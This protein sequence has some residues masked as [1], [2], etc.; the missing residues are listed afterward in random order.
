MASEKKPSNMRR[1]NGANSD[2]RHITQALRS[3]G[4]DILEPQSE[5]EI[6]FAEALSAFSSFVL[7]DE[8]TTCR[9]IIESYLASGDERCGGV[10]ILQGGDE[11]D[12]YRLQIRDDDENDDDEEEDGGYN[13]NPGTAAAKEMLQAFHSSRQGSRYRKKLTVA[14]LKKYLLSMCERWKQNRPP[15]SAESYRRYINLGNLMWILSFGSVPGQ[16]RHIDNIDPNNQICCYMSD[17]CPSTLVYDLD[18]PD[19]VCAEDLVEYWDEMLDD[20]VP[21]HIKEM[22]ASICNERLDDPSRRAYIPPRLAAWGSINETLSR[23]GKLYRPVRKCLSLP[24]DP[25]TTLVAGG[26]EVHAGP[27]TKGPRMFAFAV[28]M[29]E[30]DYEENDFG[31]H[32]D[33]GVDSGDSDDDG[34]SNQEDESAYKS[35]D[36]EVQYCPALLHLDLCS[37]LFAVMKNEYSHRD[38][39][40]DQ[41]S[42]KLFLIRILV[43]FI[44]ENPNETYSQNLTDGKRKAQREWIEKLCDRIQLNSGYDDLIEEVVTCDGIICGEMQG[45]AGDGAKKK[46]KGRS[47]KRRK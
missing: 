24:A 18:G 31:L 8:A 45:D 17:H 38:S 16:Y 30:A 44:A 19:I 3:L 13:Q 37:I 1:T 20:A 5:Y 21:N 41:R 46:A 42:S 28:G 23:F 14:K 29:P 40:S 33:G 10:G 11:H 4:V 7:I 34:K 36:G 32:F 2:E 12:I 27:P 9:S 6:E 39:A 26:N 43:G 22:F 35:G 25:G 15:G 47:G